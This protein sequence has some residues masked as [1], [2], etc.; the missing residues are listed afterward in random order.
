MGSPFNILVLDTETTGFHA[1]ARIVEIAIAKIELPSGKVLGEW[2]ALVDPECSIP[3]AAT[4]CHGITDAMVR[5]QLKTREVL[6]KVAYAFGRTPCFVAHGASYDSRILRT[7]ANR[8]GVVFPAVATF[9]SVELS[10]K[11]FPGEASYSLPP[12]AKRL[13]IEVEESHRALADVRTTVQ[14][15]VKCMERVGARLPGIDTGAAMFSLV[16]PKRLAVVGG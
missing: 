4:R 14:L 9:C 11:C 7:Q 10:R 3:D 8:V 12:L 16:K 5:G 15:L 6:Q 1:A 2:S 13:G